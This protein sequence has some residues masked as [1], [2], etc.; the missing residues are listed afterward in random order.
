MR[1]YV[2]GEKSVP[3]KKIDDR[4]L[5]WTVTLSLAILLAIGI[6][7]GVI[8]PQKFTTPLPVNVLVP[9]YLKPEESSWRA[10]EDA[11]VSR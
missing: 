4:V 3:S 1:P 9:F 6:P 8:L 11:Y 10:L 2:P 7:L 5:A